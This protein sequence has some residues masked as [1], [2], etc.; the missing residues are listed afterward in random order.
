MPASTASGPERDL[1]VAEHAGDAHH[2]AVEDRQ[3]EQ[4]QRDG[5]RG[6]RRVVRGGLIS[7]VMARPNRF[8]RPCNRR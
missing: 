7:D 2:A 1:L 6:E 3:G 5:G 8:A 4:R